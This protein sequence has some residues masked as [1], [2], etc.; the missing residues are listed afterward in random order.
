[1]MK[2]TPDL[3][4]RVETRLVMLPSLYNYLKL[5]ELPNLELETIIRQEF[6]ENPLLEEIQ[7]E[8]EE[9]MNAEPTKETDRD[10]EKNDLSLVEMFSEGAQTSY[11]G[12][13]ED[14]M[15]PLD[16]VPAEEDRLYDHLMRQAGRKLKDRELEIAE[17]VIPNVEED[18][19]LSLPPE[20]LMQDNYR[21]EEIQDVIKK[22]QHFDPVGCAWRDM[23]EPL[24]TQLETMGYDPES[25]ECRLIRDHL[26]D[27][28]S[29]QVKYLIEKF[30]IS[31]DDLKKAIRVIMKL[32]P[33]PGWRYSNFVSKYII[34]DFTV[35]WQDNKL[36]AAINDEHTSRIRIKSQYLEM[37]KNPKGIPR[38]EMEFV[39]KKAQAARELI[40]A[41]E[42]R[43]KTLHRILNAL[44]EYQTE[45]FEKGYSGLKPITM[46]EFAHQLG[47]HPSTIS[48]AIANKYL[49]SPWGIH[50]TKYFFTAP[51]GQNGQTD[52][53]IIFDKIKEMIDHEDKSAPLSDN[54]IAKKLSREGIIISRRTVTKYRE[55]VNIPS[56]QYRRKI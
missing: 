21:L 46:T 50:K 47:V 51:V 12:G 6:E 22:I 40:I 8:S 42:K 33:K 20:E 43:R 34:P 45:F 4:H 29:N 14:E 15:D 17:L 2:R 31:E 1:M 48:R 7:P 11:E 28:R 55:L 53:R 16:N 9:D 3:Q 41:I 38:E 37:L 25:L 35:C 44:L 30:N 23:R 26:K 32:D 36:V 24:L 13:Y 49:E 27:L 54:Q 19:Y 52:K 10:R 5:L 56:H 18:G 39:R